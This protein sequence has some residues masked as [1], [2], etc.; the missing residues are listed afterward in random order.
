[1][2]T[3]SPRHDH[4]DHDQCDDG[5]Q[6]DHH[7][8]GESLAEAQ[9][10]GQRGEANAGSQTGEGSEPA[11]ALGLGG[12]RCGRLAGT[13]RARRSLLTGRRAAV[14]LHG[15]GLLFARVLAAADAGRL[16]LT[17]R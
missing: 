10:T 15:V 6:H 11:V 4:A 17:D 2:P 12:R 8:A 3:A 7:D 13:L 14:T 1:V 16:C 5:K 9:M